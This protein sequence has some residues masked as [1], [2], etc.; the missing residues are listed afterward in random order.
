MGIKDIFALKPV[1]KDERL[2]GIERILGTDEEII[3]TVGGTGQGKVAGIRLAK[4][5]LV[6]T[7]KR[8]LFYYTFGKKNENYGVEDY[9]LDEIS[10]I[11]FNRYALAGSI[12]IHSNNNV[13]NVVDI[14]PSEDIEGF[15][16][17]T[18][19]HIEKYKKQSSQVSNNNLDVA[20]QI[21]KLAELRDKGILTEEEFTTQKK[22]LL[23]L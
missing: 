8:V 11:N 23:G 19:Q 17:A 18:N 1:K 3:T 16:K 13:I 15:V 20:G 22:K 2:E 7:P 12:K 9:S 6:L 14:P 21:S 10:S 4:G 5:I